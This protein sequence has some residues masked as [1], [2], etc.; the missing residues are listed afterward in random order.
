MSGRIHDVRR[1]MSLASILALMGAGLA[2]AEVVR[3]TTEDGVKIV[4]DLSLPS[5]TKDRAPVA[6][7]LHMYRSDR[8]AWKPLVP[9]LTQAGFVVLAIDLRGHGE[10]IEPKSQDLAQKVQSRDAA[11]FNA[12]YRDV[13]AGYAFLGKRKDTNMSR[14]AVIGASVGCS[15]AIDY[16]ARQPRV[17][18]IVCMTPGTNY[19]G[20]DSTKPIV[21]LSDRPTLLL[22]TEDERGATDSLCKLNAKVTCEIVGKGRV[23]GTR[24]FGKI[25]G[26]EK[27]IVAFVKA[28]VA[29]KTISKSE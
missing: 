17:G 20:L 21:K 14:V 6:I 25:A 1:L 23:H 27:K 4:G 19:L 28:G 29:P 18:A 12:M 8:S 10:S 26:V 9:K 24:M 3:F 7:L 16:A 11:L 22:A 2:R 5:A 13:E 15:V